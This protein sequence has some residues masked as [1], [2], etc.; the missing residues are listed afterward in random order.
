MYSVF[1]YMDE[2]YPILVHCRT[3]VYHNTMLS[4]FALRCRQPIRIEYY[5]TQKPRKLSTTVQA[6]LFYGRLEQ[7]DLLLFYLSCYIAELFPILEHCWGILYLITLLRSSQSW[8]IA[9]EYPDLLHCWAVAHLIT[10]LRHT[11]SNYSAEMFPILKHCWRILWLVTL[12]R[13]SQS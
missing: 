9:D 10:L 1:Y 8:N 12:L 6:P 11:L 4:V 3:M 2:L 5:I 7:D 13:C